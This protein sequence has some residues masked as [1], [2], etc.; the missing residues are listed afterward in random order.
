MSS[1]SHLYKSK[2]QA[3]I[4]AMETRK[5]IANMFVLILQEADAMSGIEVQA[6]YW[7]NF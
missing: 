5:S 3:Q 4:H 6:I 1:L 2:T 7:G